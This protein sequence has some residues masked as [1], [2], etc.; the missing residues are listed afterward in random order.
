MSST[1]RRCTYCGK[2]GHT[3]E[4]CPRTWNGNAK[5]A[6]GLYCTFCGS[7]THTAEFCPKTYSG[8]SNRRKRPN[9]DFID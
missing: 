6:W 8:L 4:T 1:Q 3:V 9:G 5:R 7:K 2:H